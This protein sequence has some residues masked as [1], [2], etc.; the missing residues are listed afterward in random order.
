KASQRAGIATVFQEVLVVEPRSVLEN[1]WVGTEGLL[2]GGANVAGKRE[3]AAEVLAELLSAPPPLDLPA[4]ALSLSDRQACCIARALVRDP[5]ILI[6]DEATSALDVATR[7]RLFALLRRLAGE[8][9]GVIFISHR[10]DEIAEIG[11][12]CTVMR[13][14]ETVATLERGDA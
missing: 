7:D 2:R 3:R 13:S 9:V 5:R 4:E 12:R 8:G 10:M 11:D 6:L 1:V 14:G